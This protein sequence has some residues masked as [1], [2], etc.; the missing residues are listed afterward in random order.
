M[1]AE[2]RVAALAAR[3]APVDGEAAVAAVR[4]HDRLVKPAGSLGRVEATGVREAFAKGPDDA[5]GER[6]RSVISALSCGNG[7]IHDSD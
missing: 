6:K 2:E 3:V 4:R 1:E 5:I 7:L